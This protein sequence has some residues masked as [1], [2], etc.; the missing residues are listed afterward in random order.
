MVNGLWQIANEHH[1]HF[2][3]TALSLGLAPLL[4][5]VRHNSHKHKHVLAV[6]PVL[7]PLALGCCDD[8]ARIHRQS[9]ETGS[10]P[11]GVLGLPPFTKLVLYELL[12]QVWAALDLDPSRSG[13][14]CRCCVPGFQRNNRT[15][16]T[17]HEDRDRDPR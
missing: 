4:P 16:P 12:V 5:V 13:I 6:T 3:G 10:E 14:A 7:A 9:T 11:K 17:A 2:A 8:R 15:P 1:E